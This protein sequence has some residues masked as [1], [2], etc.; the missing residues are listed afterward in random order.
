MINHVEHALRENMFCKLNTEM[1]HDDVIP[2]SP[3]MSPIRPLQSHSLSHV[4]SPSQSHAM[5]MS[6]LQANTSHDMFIMS[7]SRTNTPSCSC[8]MLLVVPVHLSRLLFLIQ[9]CR[10]VTK[11]SSRRSH[12]SRCSP[13]VFVFLFSLLSARCLVSKHVQ[14]LTWL[15][16]HRMG[17][18]CGICAPRRFSLFTSARLKK[19]S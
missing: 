6:Q 18:R 17:S 1:E 11:K 14:R 7:V 2:H 5:S 12:E 13:S 9:C 19:Q 8:V 10:R 3:A 16:V 4:Q 15:R